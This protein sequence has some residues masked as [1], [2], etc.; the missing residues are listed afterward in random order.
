[1]ILGGFSM[2]RLDHKVALITGAAGG[3][4]R[5]TAIRMAEEGA[6]IALVDLNV[7]GGE[8]TKKLVEEIGSKSIFIQA[9]VSKS[10]D[11]Q[12]YVKKTIEEFGKIDIFFNN[13][14]IEGM[15]APVEDYDEDEFDK[16][17]AIN[18]KGVFLGL[19]YVLKEMKKQGSGSVINTSSIGG[20]VGHENFIGYVA[21]KHA[22][23]GMTKDAAIEYG[24]H[25]IRVNAIAP[26]PINT[27]MVKN[28]AHKH[29]PDNPQEY[30]DLVTSLV[31]SRMIGEPEHVANLVTFLGSD[32]SPYINGAIIAIDGAMTAI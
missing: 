29:N 18:V 24:K 27:D 23:S 17:I 8:E 2:G 13:A 31:P 16:V 4:G 7:E 14:G 22:V 19:K 30:Y 20:L 15:V 26:G 9:D 1:M 28:A 21:S 6:K 12:N 3:L 11:V 25:G 10:S 32:E 5:Q